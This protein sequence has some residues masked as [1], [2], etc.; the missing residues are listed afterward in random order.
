M[1]DINSF[2]MAPST[3]PVVP[4]VLSQLYLLRRDISTCFSIDPDNGGQLSTQALW[5]GVMAICAG[6]DLL[7]KFLAGNDDIG[8]VGP[9][10]R[11]FLTT[12]FGI[13]QNEATTVYQLR[14]SLLHSFGL[15]S[16]ITNNS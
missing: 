15:Y 10:F 5:P 1:A 6:I 2:F 3:P 13:S 7:G 16:E 4:G 8:G 12:F 11:T 9:R 14:N